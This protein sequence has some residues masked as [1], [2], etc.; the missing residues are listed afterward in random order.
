MSLLHSLSLHDAL[1]IFIL[2]DNKIDHAITE[3]ANTVK[4]DH[5]VFFHLSKIK[6]GITEYTEGVI[7][8]SYSE[9]HFALKGFRSSEEPTS[10]L[11]SPCNLV[12]GLLLVFTT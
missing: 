12:C 5:R 11:Q 10:A 4:Q 9:D 6:K 1:P 2:A 8:D 7:Y 3:I